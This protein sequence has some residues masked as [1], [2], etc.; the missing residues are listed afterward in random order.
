MSQA[1][2]QKCNECGQPFNEWACDYCYT[3]YV[4]KSVGGINNAKIR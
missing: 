2:T 1:I 3:K 4:L